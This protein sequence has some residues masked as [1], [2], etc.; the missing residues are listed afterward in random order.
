MVN[1]N[2]KKLG[3]LLGL[4]I[5]DSLG[6]T[7][8]F[9]DKSEIYELHTEIIGGGVYNWHPGE[10]T[11]DTEMM[12]CLLNSIADL[13]RFDQKDVAKR[14][15]DWFNKNPKDVGNT[16]SQ[17]LNNLNRGMSL[18]S[19]GVDSEFGQGNGSLMRCAPMALLPFSNLSIKRQCSIT[20]AHQ[21]CVYCDQIFILL[22]Q[23]LIN[24]LSKEEAFQN[25]LINSKKRDTSI[26]LLMEQIPYTTLDEFVKSGY[27]LETL[28]C[29]AW[30]FIYTN[31]FE[32]ALIKIVN[33]GGDADTY[34]AITGAIAGAYYG[35]ESI[36]DRW[37]NV[38]HKK[39]E[40]VMA[41]LRILER[42][43]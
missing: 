15:L 39:N 17:A 26:Y 22:L 41:T 19:C 18:S 21:M 23:D 7:L 36:P 43:L 14:Y 11:D 8:E 33:E 34:G 13:G 4:H 40:I 20:H 3:M 5:G 10:P 1:I 31:S 32:E 2:N 12:L 29:T 37:G 38:I 35:L 28:F 6:A 42:G 16:I 24:G 30:A 25:L 27:V 9:T